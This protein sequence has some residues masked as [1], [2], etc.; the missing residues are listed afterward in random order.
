MTDNEF[1]NIFDDFLENQHT[2]CEKISKARNKLNRD[3]EEYLNA[4]QEDMFRQAYEYAR[5]RAEAEKHG[6]NLESR[7]T[8]II[9]E[10]IEFVSKSADNETFNEFKETVIRSAPGSRRVLYER[11]FETIVMRCLAY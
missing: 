8:G 11:I 1:D 6:E 10:L 9:E 3:F 2:C 4:V 5:T 7:L